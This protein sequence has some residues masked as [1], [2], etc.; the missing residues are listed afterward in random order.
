[1]P[2]RREGAAAGTGIDMRDFFR[3][4]RDGWSWIDNVMA[5]LSAAVFVSSLELTVLRLW[6]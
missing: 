4:W 2:V 5:S 1:M 3:Q 6:F